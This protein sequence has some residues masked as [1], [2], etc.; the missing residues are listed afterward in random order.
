MSKKKKFE[1]QESE[2]IEDCLDRMKREGYFP[3]KRLEKPVFEEV[4]K[5]GKKEVIPQGR[6]IIFEGEQVNSEQ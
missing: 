6:I 4:M 3:V 2:T 5:N 1:V